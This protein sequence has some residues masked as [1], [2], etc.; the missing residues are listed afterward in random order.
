MSILTVA[1]SKHKYLVC[2]HSV[3]LLTQFYPCIFKVFP[4]VRSMKD[5]LSSFP[6]A[7]E[8]DYIKIY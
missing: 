6:F 8:Y 3:R 7:R 1:P 2:V 4:T 5:W